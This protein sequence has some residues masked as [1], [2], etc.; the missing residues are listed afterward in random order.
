MNSKGKE[1]RFG[2]FDLMIRPPRLHHLFI[3]SFFGR[4]NHGIEYQRKNHI[5]KGDAHT[6]KQNNQDNQ[7]QA[8]HSRHRLEKIDGSLWKVF[9]LFLNIIL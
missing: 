4:L 3:P 5:S 2:V 8:Q 9:F 1:G 6:A 7:E